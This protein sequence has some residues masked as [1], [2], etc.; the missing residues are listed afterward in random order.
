[1]YLFVHFH[2]LFHSFSYPFHAFSSNRSAIRDASLISNPGC[3][4]TGA[5]L[6]LLPLIK[7]IGVS[8]SPSVFGV[9]GYSGAGTS[10]SKNND[11]AYLKDN[12]VP[13][14]LVDHMHEREVSHQLGTPINFMPHVAPFFRGITLTVNVPLTRSVTKGELLDIFGEAYSGEALIKVGAEV[15]V[16]KDNSG[17]HHVAIGGFAVA[18]NRAVVV[19]TLDNLLKG[20]ATQ[21]LQN[22]NL[23]YG[24]EELAGIKI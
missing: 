10:P 23:A 24:F 18:N 6:A 3:Y 21:A 15:P 12:L 22:I 14:T 9:S 16:V 20:A 4:A 5:Q 8:A 19:A 2:S 11:P 7:T 1:M 17:K 13:Y